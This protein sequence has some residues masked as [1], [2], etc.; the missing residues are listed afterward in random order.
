MQ[1]LYTQTAADGP[2]KETTGECCGA[3]VC[4]GMGWFESGG[5]EI[6]A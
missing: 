1:F 2:E 4:S 6:A 5:T 3:V